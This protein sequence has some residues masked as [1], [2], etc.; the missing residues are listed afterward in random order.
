MTVRELRDIL[1]QYENTKTDDAEIII[2]DY[3]H[4]DNPVG[5]KIDNVEDFSSCNT[6][7]INV[8]AKPDVV[9]SEDSA[10]Q[11]KE[12]TDEDAKI[13]FFH[14]AFTDE[15]RNWRWRKA[16]NIAYMTLCKLEKIKQ[17]SSKESTTATENDLTDEYISRKALMV[18]LSDYY[19]TT[20]EYRSMLKEIAALPSVTLQLSSEL[21]KS[22]SDCISRKSVLKLIYDYKENH[23][24]DRE[25]YPINYGT[26]LDM[27]R[28][29]V[30]L[31]SVAS[32]PRKGHW[33]N[34][35]CDKCGYVV[36]PW[37]TTNFCPNCG[38]MKEVKNNE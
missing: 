10:E 25:H 37:N 20:V 34:C 38:D 24:N 33:I 18:I 6:I 30:Y 14:E 7:G 19:D 5:A 16:C 35:K 29:V 28:W 22:E 21:D 15:K 11:C 12:I 31:P 1:S 27:I 26:L 2:F 32:Q 4:T 23:F 17:S 9:S 36:Q 8:S 3:T 13:I